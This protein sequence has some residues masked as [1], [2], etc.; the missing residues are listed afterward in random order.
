[1]TR[2]VR[3][4]ELGGP[5]VL[6]IEEVRLPEPGE[7]EVRIRVRALGLNRAEALLRSGAYIESATLPSG[8]GLEAAGVVDVLGAG[9]ECLMVGDA[10]SVIPPKSM[11]RWPTYSEVAIL[12]A[13]LLVRH[14]PHLSFEDAAAIWMAYL[15]AYGG[16]V[17]VGRLAEGDFVAITAASSSVGV[18]A[19]QIANRLGAVPIAITSTPAKRA[20]L[21]AAGAIHVVVP[22]KENLTAQLKQLT[23]SAG[24]RVVFDPVGGP[25]VEALADA[26]TTGGILVEYGGLSAAPTPLPLAAL[27]GKMLTVRGYL[28]HEITQH[29]ARLA[30]AKAF[31]LDGLASGAFKPTIAR[32]FCFDDIVEAH[33]FMESNSQFGKIVVKV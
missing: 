31:I 12:P 18:A 15:T 7:G 21:E 25:Q 10:V 14:P 32:T 26:M 30:K 27:L 8:L 24:L 1:M 19:I 20:A 2:V 6:R 33:R 17:E 16:L 5:D 9:V 23:G 22:G 4:H 11:L 28:V 29:P 3:F 13:S